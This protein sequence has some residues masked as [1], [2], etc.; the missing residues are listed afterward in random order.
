MQD[1][2]DIIKDP[3]VLEFL[4]LPEP[5][6][7]KQLEDKIVN[8]LKMFLLELGN[9]FS[10]VARQYRMNIG[11]KQFYADLVFYNKVLRCYVLI[12][13]KVRGGY[14][15]VGQMGIYLNYFR[16]HVNSKDDNEPI[17]II[18]FK[19][20]DNI[21]VKYALGGLSSRIFASKYML[22]LPSADELRMIVNNSGDFCKSMGTNE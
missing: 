6:S 3:Y 20:N 4:S 9:G 21:E 11:K 22:S 7:E 1:A 13:L 8:N 14:S 19:D 5:Y 17:G 12:D 2:E 10:F 15:G 18:L 16:L